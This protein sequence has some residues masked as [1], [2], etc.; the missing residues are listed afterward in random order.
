MVRVRV[1]QLIGQRQSLQEETQVILL[2][3][4][5]TFPWCLFACKSSRLIPDFQLKSLLCQVTSR[6]WCHVVITHV[7]PCLL[8]CL[9]VNMTQKLNECINHVCTGML[10]TLE[11]M[12]LL[13]TW[14]WL[15]DC[16]TALLQFSHIVPTELLMSKV[17]LTGEIK[18]EVIAKVTA[19]S[20]ACGF[21]SVLQM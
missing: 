3:T 13:L 17:L 10:V 6:S 9:T 7:C 11:S 12:L 16:L 1:R 2:R 14:Q 18:G 20:G 15:P 5:P 8:L 19:P 21:S 4:S